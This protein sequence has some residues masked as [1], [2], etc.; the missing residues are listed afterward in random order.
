MT[1][2]DSDEKRVDEIKHVCALAGCPSELDNLSN[3]PKTSQRY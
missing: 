3:K 2:N 1:E